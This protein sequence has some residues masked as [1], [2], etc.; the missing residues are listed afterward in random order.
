MGPRSKNADRCPRCR[1][2]LERCLC[3]ELPSL[4]IRT[5]VVLVMH[6]REVSK[7]TATG[8]LA[9]AALPGSEILVH[10]EREQPLDLNHLHDESSRVLL[11]FPSED[12][13]PLDEFLREHE[14][15]SPGEATRFTLVVPDGNWRQASRAA[16]RIPGL[17][18]ATRVVLPRGATTEWGIRNEPK[19]GGLATF[20]AIARALGLLESREIQERLET[21]FRRMVRQTWEA[22]GV[23]LDPQ[24]QPQMSLEPRALS[25]RSIEAE[26][27]E[28]E[29]QELSILYRDEFFVAVH[30]PAGALVHRGWGR[31][32][33]PLLQ[34]LRDQL[35]QWVY[36]VHRLD[37]ATSGV[38]LFSLSSEFTRELQA[39][40]DSGS[41]GKFYLALC[42][43]RD[44]SLTRVDH[45]LSREKGGEKRPAVT[46][47]RFLGAEGRYG[48]FEAR[49]LTGRV[50][51]IR[52]HLKHVSHPLIGDV[53][54]GKGDHNRHFR[55]KYG[56]RRLAL[57][58]HKLELSHPRTGQKLVLRAEL[59]RDYAEVL[60]ALGLRGCLDVL[61]TS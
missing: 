21:L 47:L 26:R 31:D 59:P 45:P 48:L 40:F 60:D 53:R 46:E 51:Q 8:P 43:G 23:V 3:D 30:K 6:H 44:A 2:H 56:F 36:P 16:R 41:V 33:R 61:E 24:G 28:P 39:Q 25:E 50:H 42:R 7:T 13:Q 49:P 22:R 27:E 58:C 19:S 4:S 57:H 35:G 55:E 32:A 14:A 37:R 1:L 54:Y 52:R 12:A 34:I 9:V 5:R 18:R 20:E 29:E 17:E 15:S 11:L 38:L 10:G